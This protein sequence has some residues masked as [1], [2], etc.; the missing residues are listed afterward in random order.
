MKPVHSSS[1]LD[2]GS[3]R[4]GSKPFAVSLGKDVSRRLRMEVYSE[5]D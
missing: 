2:T 1:L 4:L 5:D 3:I